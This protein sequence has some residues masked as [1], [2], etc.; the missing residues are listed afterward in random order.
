MNNELTLHHLE[1]TRSNEA[2]DRDWFTTQTAL[3]ELEMQ[4]YR[5]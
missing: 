3:L 4:N 2:V 1:T 5:T